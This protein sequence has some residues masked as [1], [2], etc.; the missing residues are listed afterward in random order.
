VQGNG[1]H[2]EALVKKFQSSSMFQELHS[3]R[4]E[5]RAEP[6]VKS[7]QRESAVVVGRE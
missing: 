5:K 6:R 7:E 2:D 4:S 3:Q 1:S